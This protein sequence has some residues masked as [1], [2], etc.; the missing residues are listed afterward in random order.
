M[1]LDC[2]ALGDVVFFARVGRLDSKRPRVSAVGRADNSPLHPS[3]A[4]GA[5]PWTAVNQVPA[6]PFRG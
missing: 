6:R 3:E 4:V 2:R 5:E 1:P